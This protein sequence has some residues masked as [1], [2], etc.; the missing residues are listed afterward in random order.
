MVLPVGDLSLNIKNAETNELVR[1]DTMDPRQRTQTLLA[2][3]RDVA[4]RLVEPYRSADHGD[5]PYD[6]QGLPR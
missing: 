1:H 2:I 4:A 3:G 6:D 5:L